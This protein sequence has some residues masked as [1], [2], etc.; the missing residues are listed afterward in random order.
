MFN[1]FKILDVISLTTAVQSVCVA[2][3]RRG[4]DR[5][6]ST[7]V[8]ESSHAHLR[9]AVGLW[10][11]KEHHLVLMQIRSC[12]D[13]RVAVVVRCLVRYRLIHHGVVE[14]HHVLWSAWVG[15]EKGPRLCNVTCWGSGVQEYFR[16]GPRGYPVVVG[17][18]IVITKLVIG[19]M[20]VAEVVAEAPIGL[21][22]RSGLFKILRDLQRRKLKSN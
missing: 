5:G 15:V 22:A 20:A 10:A 13:G 1:S 21:V 12:A 2:L 4:D 14:R 17:E 9:V 7:S 16:L 18:N 8:R 11:R 19:A 3:K 6:I